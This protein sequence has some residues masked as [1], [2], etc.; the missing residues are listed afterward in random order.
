MYLKA[1]V[2]YDL[3]IYIHQKIMIIFYY[4]E[5]ILKILTI[6]TSIKILKN[7]PI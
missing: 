7:C 1:I 3:S 2:I 6:L 4:A 5:L